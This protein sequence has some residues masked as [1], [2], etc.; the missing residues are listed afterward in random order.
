VSETLV[1]SWL[2]R[3]QPGNDVALALGVAMLLVV[4]IVPLPVLLLDLGLAIS[5]T[6]S[7]L[8]LMTSLFFN[9]L[10]RSLAMMLRLPPG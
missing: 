5:I 9:G 2:K 10:I 7:I 6:L 4:L 1:P 3:A 8:V